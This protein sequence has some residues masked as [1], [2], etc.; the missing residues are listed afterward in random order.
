MHKRKRGLL[1]VAGVVALML[2]GYATLRAQATK[3][4]DRDMFHDT[5][6]G[7]GHSP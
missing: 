7:S 1:I 6:R 4:A 3:T 2:L 5:F